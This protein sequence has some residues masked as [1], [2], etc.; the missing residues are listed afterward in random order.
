M[1]NIA[2]IP[3]K[4]ES[5]RLKN[6]NMLHLGGKPLLHWTIEAVLKSNTFDEVIVSSDSHLILT[7]A[8]RKY[9]ITC[10]RRPHNLATSQSK[11]IDTIFSILRERLDSI[12][13][14]YFL[15]TCPFRSRDH[16]QDGWRLL[17]K[18][19]SVVSLKEFN[20]PPE[21]YC[22]LDEGR[23]E[24]STELRKG[25]T[26]SLLLNRKY[27]P[28]GGFY[29]AYTSFLIH[30]GGYLTGPSKGYIMDKK[31]S[32]DINDEFDLYVAEYIAEAK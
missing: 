17:T 16:I 3:A 21:L 20:H 14:S 11:V 13:F 27:H 6:K 7:E 29:M 30:Y 23:I 8:N 18:E 15:P 31:N 26:N 28:N 2:V 24:P 25:N 22:E 19:K 1:N 5:T 10:H 9:N 32:I 12:T 4:G